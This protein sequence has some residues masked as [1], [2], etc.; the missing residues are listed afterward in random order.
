MTRTTLNLDASVL[1]EVKR[2]AKQQG[3]SVGD[4]ISEIVGPALA[5]SG[6]T[7]EAPELRWQTAR[8][9]PPKVDLEDKEAVR[10]AL[11]AP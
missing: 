7:G 11:E 9:G 5:K 4:V 3:K 10:Q 1:R 8:M 2:R 6:R